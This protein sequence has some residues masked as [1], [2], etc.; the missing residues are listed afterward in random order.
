MPATTYAISGRL[1]LIQFGSGPMQNM[2]YMLHDKTENKMV[3]IDP[4]WTTVPYIDLATQHHAVVSEIW[5]T[6][7]HFD[8]VN[9]L[10]QLIAA[11]SPVRVV[12]YTNPL[13][14]P[15]YEHLHF[16]SDGDTI[17]F[18]GETIHI[19]H[20]PGH[21]P[22]SIAFNINGHLICGDV[23]FVDACGRSDLPGSDA[24]KMKNSLARLAQL[25]PQTWIYPGHDYGPTPRATI[26]TQ[27]VT[28]PHLM[29]AHAYNLT[30]Q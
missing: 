5:I 2:Q 15:Q 3:A 9:K 25:P 24:T 6:H 1:D 17:K 20:L 8:H 22:D 4:A 10:D 18:G 7:G 28:N 27:T 14:R 13:V 29:S 19:L 30:N 12:L 16:V 11:T 21:S 26:E 23:L